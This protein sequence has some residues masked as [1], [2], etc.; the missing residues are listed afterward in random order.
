MKVSEDAILTTVPDEVDDLAASQFVVNGLTAYAM[1][2]RLHDFKEGEWALQTASGSTVGRAIIQIAKEKG[3]NLISIVRR[4][5]QVEELTALGG[6]VIVYDGKN[7]KEVEEKIQ[8]I[9]GGR[10]VALGK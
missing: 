1:I 9:T 5:A 10:G 4:E 3:I 6:N 7:D 2:T 8:T